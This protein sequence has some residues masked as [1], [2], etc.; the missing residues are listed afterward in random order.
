MEI[1]DEPPAAG[2]L[3]HPAK[4]LNDLRVGEVMGEQRGDDNVDLTGDGV[5]ESV[6]D[7]L[8]DGLRLQC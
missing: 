3:V 7:D 2:T 8:L 4:K 5:A 1:V 6:A